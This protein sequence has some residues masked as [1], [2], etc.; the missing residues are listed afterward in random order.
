MTANQPTRSSQRGR[1][2][3][4]TTGSARG[5]G[6]LGS[7]LCALSPGIK[8][9]ADSATS[10]AIS[11][12]LDFFCLGDVVER[13]QR[14]GYYCRWVS[15][16][17]RL[18]SS[19]QYPGETEAQR[20]KRRIVVGYMVI[21][22]PPRLLFGLSYLSEGQPGR[23]WIEVLAAVIPAL[24][25]MVLR[26]KPGW[27]TWV[28]NA[29]LAGILLENL[30]A[31]LVAGGLVNA[32]LAVAFGF[33]VVVGALIAL[34]IR[35][36]WWWFLAYIVNLV[37]AVVLSDRIEPTN[38]FEASQADIAS[39]LIGTAVLLF[40]G[41]AYF[42]RQR[43]RFQRESDDLLHN[44]LPDEIAARLKSERTMIADDF[45]DA[46]VLFADIVGFTPMSAE[47]TPPQLVGLLNTVFS[48]FDGL[49][50]DLGL[51]KIKTVGD[52]YMVSS[53]T[54]LQVVDW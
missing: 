23:F 37:A 32:E 15:W 45:D 18:L 27:Y 51:E 33:V 14:D 41:V 43:D 12:R 8:L 25:L 30:A 42:V 1:D 48:T 19:G 21:G 50:A 5:A 11:C 2:Q 13:P 36:G 40:A 38:E 4:N 10:I 17:D 7:R 28:V 9:I 54:W 6:L 47:M 26:A 20:G 29:L 22:I 46:S 49:V 53:L 52:E 34:D 3:C 24:G 44:I 39:T 31:T 35:A 16:W